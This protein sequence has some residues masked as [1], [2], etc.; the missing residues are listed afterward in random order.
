M[1]VV[2][3]GRS[4]A[5]A[6]R[7]RHGGVEGEALDFEMSTLKKTERHLPRESQIAECHEAGSV[8]SSDSTPYHEEAQ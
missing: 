8:V 2:L 6:D 5:R 3:H 1:P 7:I 4:Y